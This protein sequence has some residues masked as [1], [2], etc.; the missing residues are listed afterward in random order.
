MNNCF[1]ASYANYLVQ[2]SKVTANDATPREIQFRLR[3]GGTD[4]ST[5]SS[6]QTQR[7]GAHTTSTAYA[8]LLQQA[9]MLIEQLS[10]AT[11]MNAT[12][13][14]TNPFTTDKTGLDLKANG[15]RTTLN[16]IT[17]YGQGEHS[18]TVSYDGF[19]IISASG[20]IS[21]TVR[22]YGYNS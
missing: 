15:Y 5:A 3:V 4:N 10:N 21:G 11:Q 8:E 20:T 1:S 7:V 17:V 6:Y 2:F 19:T 18:Q 14:L 13:N 12:I 9:Q 16:F 22:V